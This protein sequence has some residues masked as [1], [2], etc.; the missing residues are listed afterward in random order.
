MKY[1]I[2]LKKVLLNENKSIFYK[3]KSLTNSVSKKTIEILKNKLE[4]GELENSISLTIMFLKK[5]ISVS[6]DG[7]LSVIEDDFFGKKIKKLPMDV[8]NF[9]IIFSF[10][11]RASEKDIGDS[12]RYIGSATALKSENFVDSFIT[13][14]QNLK[15]QDLSYVYS[16]VNSL[17]IHEPT[18]LIKNS[19]YQEVGDYPESLG[20]D[21]LDFDSYEEAFQVSKDNLMLNYRY[22]SHPSELEAFTNELRKKGGN[23]DDNL[24]NWLMDYVYKRILTSITP[25]LVYVMKNQ[26][27][28]YQEL[29]QKI[30]N[31]VKKVLLNLKQKYLEFA[32]E[33]YPEYMKN[34]EQLK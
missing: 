2:K 31:G 4:S 27:E 13:L 1:K 5:A 33:R 28:R 3:L 23:F 12:S 22:F 17:F 32:Q 10:S 7:N 29:R 25:T 20:S 6:L 34:Q 30:N 16:K 19:D 8:K 15:V 21:K 11:K 14:P 18:H 26:N 24:N 9:R